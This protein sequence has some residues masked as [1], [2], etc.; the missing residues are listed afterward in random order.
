MSG[1]EYPP[2]S[3]EPAT[4][5]RQPI[6]TGVAV[7]VLVIVGGAIALAARADKGEPTP[8]ATEGAE[9]SS[10]VEVTT[11]LDVASSFL[12]AYGAYDAGLALTYLTDGAIVGFDGPD[13]LRHELA[14]NDAVGYQQLL[15]P[16]EEQGDGTSGIGV[17]CPFDMHA[18]GSDVTGLGPFTGN[19][20]DLI[21]HAG[22]I[23]SAKRTLA[24]PTNE[25]SQTVWEPFARWVATT[26]PD[27]VLAMYTDESQGVQR[28]NA[29]SIPLWEQRVREYVASDAAYTGPP[30]TGPGFIGLPPAG[31]QPSGP[32]SGELVDS[33]IVPSGNY[34][35]VGYVRLYA[36]GRLIWRMH[37]PEGV[38][39]ASTGWLE[40]RL[41]P[42]GVELVRTHGDVSA[43]HPLRLDDWLPTSAWADRQFRAYVPKGYAACLQL[44][45]PASVAE[46][47]DADT[48]TPSEELLALFPAP[49]ADLLRGRQTVPQGPGTPSGGW[50]ECLALPTEDARRLD[51]A[52]SDAG[53]E[54]GVRTYQ[55]WYLVDHPRREGAE[56]AVYFEPV[57][58][59]GSVA[60]S[61][62][63]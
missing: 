31:A 51:R 48:G 63:A 44:H 61:G 9:T 15:D 23:V 33:Y 27:D 14:W 17:R 46:V 29:E 57:F 12:E 28:V 13:G 50:D 55:L 53:L 4:R 22:T 11:A 47:L 36:D 58:P 16:C 39:S 5:H 42:E 59:D 62:C 43:K 2:A 32:E 49:A 25:F 30:Y 54:G 20:W 34:P 60:C 21:V 6:I 26:Y 37:F 7:A 19:Y 18:I 40:Q 8:L 10:A 24:F 35:Y 52:L 1:I 56:L 45:G 38:W 3:T 41:T